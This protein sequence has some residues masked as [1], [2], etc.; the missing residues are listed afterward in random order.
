MKVLAVNGS[1]RNNGNTHMALEFVAE[2]LRQE[3][4]EVEIV[5]L[6]DV[7]L[8]PFSFGGTPED[9]VP[10][11]REKLKAA[12]GL[13]IGSPTYYSNVTSRTQMFIERM[14]GSVDLKGKIGAAVAVARR[15]GA[16]FVY[17]AINYFFGIHEMPI[18]TS[19]Y[20]NIVIARKPGEI[21]KDEEGLKTLK[22]LGKNMA[23]LLKATK[24]YS[25]S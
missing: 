19:T 25:S 1:A 8:H 7:N 22:N 13:I 23:K 17:A 15:G 2:E 6:V 4:I 10:M 5:D 20:W 16:N 14:G 3:G 21:K 9:D 12:D 24:T 11:L 18:A